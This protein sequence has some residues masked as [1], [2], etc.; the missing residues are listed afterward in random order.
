MPL[1]NQDTGMVDR[2]GETRL[3]DLGLEPT[4]QEIFDL[5]G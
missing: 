4:F 2:L 1:A 5:E 3:E